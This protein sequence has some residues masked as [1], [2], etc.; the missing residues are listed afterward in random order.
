MVPQEL[1]N[2]FFRNACTEDERK[3][4]LQYFEEYPEEWNKYLNEEDWNNFETGD[5]VHPAVTNKIFE[6]VSRNTFNRNSYRTKRLWLSMAASIVLLAGLAWFVF[7]YQR[8][9]TKQ[10]NPNEG[11]ALASVQW[12]E[13]INT[14]GTNMPVSMEDGSLVMLSPNSRIRYHHPFSVNNKRAVYLQGEG[15]FKV[16]KDPGRPFTV[17]SDDVAT[18][19]LGTQFTVTSFKE[20]SE[21]N[22]ALHEGKVVVA[23]GKKNMYLVPGDVLVYNKNTMLASIRHADS[24]EHLVKAGALHKSEATVQKP[25]WYE[26]KQQSLAAVFEQLSAYYQVDIYYYPTDIRNKY[27]S[28]RMKKTDSLDNILQDIALLN[29]LSINRKNGTYIVQKRK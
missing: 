21:I 3:R 16:A 29:H 7:L 25:D 28:G 26:F 12:R 20:S 8:A 13:T 1:I 23:A 5:K 27:F 19:A 2:R 9:T 15:V 17:Y 10:G 6:Q 14:T 22:V 11:Q 4:V 24:K 18:T